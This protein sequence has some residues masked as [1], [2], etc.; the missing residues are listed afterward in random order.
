MPAGP[1]QRRISSLVL[2]EASLKYC[3]VSRI[4]QKHKHSKC[5]VG[6]D[7]ETFRTDIK[8]LKVG[9]VRK[10]NTMSTSPQ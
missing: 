8:F 3:S 9:I 4:S 10:P 6:R 7:G 1:A 5:E 2:L